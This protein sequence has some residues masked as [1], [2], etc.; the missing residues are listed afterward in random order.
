VYDFS[1]DFRVFTIPKGEANRIYV[2]SCLLCDLENFNFFHLEMIQ[3]RE[4]DVPIQSSVIGVSAA[5]GSVTETVCMAVIGNNHVPRRITKVW[6]MS[7][8]TNDCLVLH[9]GL[10]RKCPRRNVA[11]ILQCEKKTVQTIIRLHAVVIIPVLP[12]LYQRFPL[13][14]SETTENVPFRV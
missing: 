11:R 1:F 9:F 10:Q 13:Q 5:K 6:T 12:V 8:I 2:K 14:R 3:T 4:N 7:G